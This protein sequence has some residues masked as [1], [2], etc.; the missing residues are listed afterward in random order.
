MEKS[1]QESWKGLIWNCTCHK[2]NLC[3]LGLKRLHFTFLFSF[4]FFNNGSE[5]LREGHVIEINKILELMVQ[6]PSSATSQS[7][8][9]RKYL[10]PGHY[11][12]KEMHIIFKCSHKHTL[13][14]Y[15]P[16]HIYVH[17]P[18]YTNTHMDVSLCSRLEIW[19]LCQLQEW[20]GQVGRYQNK[21]AYSQTHY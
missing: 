13:C 18:I 11:C 5:N 12:L 1:H 14:V 21:G 10:V 6:S 2:T 7:T 20:V 8:N 9:P 4:F 19:L 17:E 16:M 15:K 3:P